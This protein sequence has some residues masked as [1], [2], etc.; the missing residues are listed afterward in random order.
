MSKLISLLFKFPYQRI[1]L[2]IFIYTP[3]LFCCDQKEKQYV[4]EQLADTSEDVSIIT[5][6][7]KKVIVF[8]G[9][10]ITAGYR[11]DL[12]EAF[13]FLIGEFIDSLKLN[14]RV[15]NAGL[16]GETT[17]SGNSRVEW[18]LKNQVDIFVLELGSNDGL[19]GIKTE[20][21]RKNIKG[22]I[23]KVKNKYP[24]AKIVLA[25]MQIPPNMG[26]EY[27]DSFK[28]IFPE[29]ALEYKIPLIPFILEGVAGVPELN[30]D[31]GIHPTPEG[32]MI[33]AKNIWDILSPML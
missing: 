25:G 1:L 7:N 32:H 16:S 20:E 10:S 18:V 21:T 6:S 4:K 28:H 17:S 27:S 2:L 8:F 9:N 31:D 24:E 33:L 15:V 13:P 22:I 5:E 26:Q 23:D 14:Y 11:L 12:S 30:L 19:R 29:L 3:F